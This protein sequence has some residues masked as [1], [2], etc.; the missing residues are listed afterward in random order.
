MRGRILG[1]T[2]V[3][4]LALTGCASG[5][6]GSAD[7]PSADGGKQTSGSSAAP[8]LS[9]DERNVKWAQCMRENGIDVPDP[10]AGQ[11]IRMTAG[12]GSEETMTKAREACKEWQPTGGNG[13]GNAQNG[14]R[15]RKVAQCMRD[16]GVE[17]FPDPDGNTMR[18]NKSVADDPDFPAAEKKCQ[19][20]LG[21]S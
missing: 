15:M 16:N 19:L 10:K 18:L 4:A 13:T 6:G 8:S 21:G 1:M 17:E 3:L 20:G 5:A 14:E 9:P 12:P 11:G 2:A 7:V